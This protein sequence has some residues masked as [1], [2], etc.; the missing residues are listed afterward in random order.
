MVVGGSHQ[1]LRE[2]SFAVLETSW[3]VGAELDELKYRPGRCHDALVDEVDPV[4]LSLTDADLAYFEYPS[5]HERALLLVIEDPTSLVYLYQGPTFFE[6]VPHVPESLIVG[7]PSKVVHGSASMKQA[8]RL[9]KPD[10]SQAAA[11]CAAIAG[12]A[13]AESG[14]KTV[15]FPDSQDRAVL[16]C[17]LVKTYENDGGLQSSI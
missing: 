8:F 13:V 17:D 12:M 1:R 14:A 6:T 10:V 7:N 11:A 2:D 16:V 9:S 3:L 4:V 5:H 15:A